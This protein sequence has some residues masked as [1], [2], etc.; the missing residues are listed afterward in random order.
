MDGGWWP[1]KRLWEKNGSV[2]CTARGKAPPAPAGEGG[3]TGRTENGVEEAAALRGGCG[4]WAGLGGLLAY[5][6]S[7]PAALIT[8]PHFWVSAA[9]NLASSSGVVVH[10]S[11][12]ALS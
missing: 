11:D 2:W 12:P 8:L 1:L 3:R 7:I 6:A 10:A 9:W 4:L 5:S